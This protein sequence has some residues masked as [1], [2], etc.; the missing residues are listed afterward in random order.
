MSERDRSWFGALMDEHYAGDDSDIGGCWREASWP[1]TPGSAS[2]ISR[3]PRIV[4]A[5]RGIPPWV[6]ATWSAHTPMVELL[7]HLTENGFAT[8][9]A[10]G[11]GRDFM[12]PISQELYGIPRERVIGSSARFAYDQ[13]R[14]RRH[15]HSQARGGL[16]RRR[17]GEA[18][19]DLE[20]GR[21]T[22]VARRGQLQRRHRDA[23]VHPPPRPA[24]PAAPRPPRRCRAG[25]R[26]HGWG[27]AGPQ[28]GRADGWTVVSMRNDWATIFPS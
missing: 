17:P 9:I 19:T 4:P 21:P 7:D 22:P 12:R 25:V 28:R 3:S 26:L 10:S 13:Q 20:P 14:P 27:R 1:P 24:D 8:Y 11:G 18:D 6:A 15:R 2:R 5:Q 16:P 23:G